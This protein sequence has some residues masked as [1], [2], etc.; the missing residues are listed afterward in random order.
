MTLHGKANHHNNQSTIPWVILNFWCSPYRFAAP[1]GWHGRWRWQGGDG[2]CGRGR[3]GWRLGFLQRVSCDQHPHMA[4]AG[5]QHLHHLLTGQTPSV[6]LTDPQDVVPCSQPP[7]LGGVN[8]RMEEEVEVIIHE[9]NLSIHTSIQ[10]S[11]PPS[12]I[13]IMQKRQYCKASRL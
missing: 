7:V 13:T 11:A 8:E 2:S 5:L 6:G 10:K 1:A 9:V 4:T 12:Q 3:W